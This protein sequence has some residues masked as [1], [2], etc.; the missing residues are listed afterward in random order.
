MERD[1]FF[2]LG[3]LSTKAL[4]CDKVDNILKDSR[5]VKHETASVNFYT[6][7][8]QPV[9]Q[10]TSAMLPNT[11]VRYHDLSF[12]QSWFTVVCRFSNVD[13]LKHTNQTIKFPTVTIDL[14]RQVFRTWKA[15][16]S[17]SGDN[18]PRFFHSRLQFYHWQQIL[19]IILF[20]YE[21]FVFIFRIAANH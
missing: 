6:L 16:M 5:K 18:H 3:I 17:D 13:T 15:V 1:E 19:S 12:G 7:S 21:R 14:I 4:K 9:S 2:S 8:H 11:L 20:W 10:S